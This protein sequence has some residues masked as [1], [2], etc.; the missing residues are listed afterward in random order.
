MVE[1]KELS[2]PQQIAILMQKAKEAVAAGEQDKAV[3]YAM[4]AA[5]ISSNGNE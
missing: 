3:A 5:K 4:A 2:A 1:Q